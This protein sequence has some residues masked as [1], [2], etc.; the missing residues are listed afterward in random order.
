[1][2]FMKGNRVGVRW[3][4]DR[5]KRHTHH[6]ARE[7]RQ[8]DDWGQENTALDREILIVFQ[9]KPLICFGHGFRRQDVPHSIVLLDNYCTYVFRVSH[10][11]TRCPPPRSVFFFSPCRTDMNGSK[12]MSRAQLDAKRSGKREKLEAAV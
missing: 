1:M 12:A 9:W 10:L 11:P 7:K 3:Q 4:P 2:S 6:R 8:A 5:W